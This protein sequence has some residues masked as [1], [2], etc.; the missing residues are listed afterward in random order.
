MKPTWQHDRA[1]YEISG[2]K[3]LRNGQKVIEFGS[4]KELETWYSSVNEIPPIP[5]TGPGSANDYLHKV[6]W[7]AVL[8]LKTQEIEKTI[9]RAYTADDKKKIVER[10]KDSGLTRKEFSAQEGIPLG[11][12]NRF[13]KGQFTGQ[14]GKPPHK[15][16]ERIQQ[17][18]LDGYKVK[19]IMEV[20]EKE[21]IRCSEPTIRK[22]AKIAT[23][24]VEP[25]SA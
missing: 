18:T 2:L 12:L 21:G 9:R 10:L 6:A 8:A 14:R 17:M 24:P 11:T 3:I 15:Q 16:A 5:G 23:V 7:S 19:D 22:Y 25:T 1:T 20:F 4:Q 13:C